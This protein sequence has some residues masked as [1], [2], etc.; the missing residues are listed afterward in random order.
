MVDAVE[1]RDVGE[2][3]VGQRCPDRLREDFAVDDAGDGG[4]RERV[5]ERVDRYLA[6]AV[7]GLVGTTNLVGERLAEGFGLG[8][9]HLVQRECAALHDRPLE[10]TTRPVRDKMGEHRD[11][12]GGL[13]GNRYLMRVAAELRDVVPDP[14]QRL[15]LIHE[16]VVAGRAAGPRGKRGMR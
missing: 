2:V 9:R 8:E 7:G 3:A 12:T 15:L 1:D 6:Q 13:A 10:Q 4:G 16:A 14:A 11:A 5:D